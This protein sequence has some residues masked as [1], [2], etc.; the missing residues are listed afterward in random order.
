MADKEDFST[1]AI[2]L[3]FEENTTSSIRRLTA[4]LAEVTGN[5]FMTANAVPPHLTLGMFHVVDADVGKLKALFEDFVSEV[6]NNGF[7]FDV[8]FS[9]YESF[10]DKVIF[11]K[12]VVDERLSSLNRILHE[13]F[14]PDF[15][16]AD[17]RNYLPE[18]WYPHIALGVKLSHEQFEK[19]MEFLNAQGIGG[20]PQALQSNGGDSRNLGSDGVSRQKAPV[21]RFERVSEQLCCEG[22]KPGLPIGRC[23]R[24]TTIGLACCNPYTPILDSKI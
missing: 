1:Y 20:A 13:K 7:S 21:E 10:L 24:I 6:R 15:E 16:P 12:P 2:T 4:G 18:N 14:L 11:I 22:S 9:G 8:S 17:N 3:Y 19:G 5:E 23:A